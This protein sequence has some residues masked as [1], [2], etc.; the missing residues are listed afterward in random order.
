MHIAASKPEAIDIDQLSS[1][2]IENEKKIQKEMIQDSGKPSNVIEK[3]LEG[4]IKKFYSEVTLLNQNF[5]I[6][7]EKT[8]KEAINEIKSSNKFDLKKYALMSL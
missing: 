3:I 6:D 1:S 4:K 5:V 8:I 2:V 7:P